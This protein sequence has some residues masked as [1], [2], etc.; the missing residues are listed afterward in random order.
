MRLAFAPRPGIGWI[1]GPVANFLA[2][3]FSARRLTYRLMT[4]RLLPSGA[5]VAVFLLGACGSDSAPGGTP[6]PPSGQVP[7][8]I[9]V[10]VCAQITEAT[11]LSFSGECSTCCQNAGFED[12]SSIND[13]KCTCGNM[14]DSGG[15]TVCASQNATSDACGACCTG[16][17]YT[18]NFWID[19]QSCLCNGKKNRTVCASAVSDADAC[20]HCCLGNGFLGFGFIG[21]TGRS[22]TCHGK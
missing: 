10:G 21:T 18:I 22:C 11:S 20:A 14:P 3:D 19:G 6:P 13:D 1:A 8:Y 15:G 9:D 7:D 16:A 4:C 5:S 12:S 17:D 2:G